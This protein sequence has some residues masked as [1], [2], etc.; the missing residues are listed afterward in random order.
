MVFIILQSL[1]YKFSYFIIVI[2]TRLDN[3]EESF[4]LDNL[5]RTLLK[6]EE[7]INKK[8]LGSTPNDHNIILGATKP[9]FK[10]SHHNNGRKDGKKY[11]EGNVKSNNSNTKTKFDGNC[12]FS[13]IYG[14]K[15]FHCFKKN[16]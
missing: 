5:S 6:H 14:H 15:E 9:H 10:N 8:M 4:S 16:K 13:S 12:N 2:E 7:A 11:H 3:K 1:L